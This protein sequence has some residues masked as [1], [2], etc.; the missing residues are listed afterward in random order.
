MFSVYERPFDVVNDIS[1]DV[2]P[3]N[4]HFG[5]GLHLL[6]PQVRTMEVKVSLQENTSLDG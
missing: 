3:V 6:H 5:L 2:W 4:C 1:I